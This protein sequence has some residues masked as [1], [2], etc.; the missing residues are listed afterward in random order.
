[1]VDLRLF[2][3]AH[4]VLRLRLDVLFLFED[5]GFFGLDLAFPP[6]DFA[7]THEDIFESVRNTLLT[8]RRT[9]H[10]LLL[11]GGHGIGEFLMFRMR[12]CHPLAVGRRVLVRL[13]H[14]RS[15]TA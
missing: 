1:M 3:Q 15:G 10:A 13:H 4:D 8:L 9:H 14:G 2:R 7:F 12:L 5:A 6:I 11:F